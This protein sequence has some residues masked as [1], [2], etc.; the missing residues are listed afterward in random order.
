MSEA[1]VLGRFVPEF[2]AVTDRMQFNMYHHYTVDEHTLRA[3]D[4]IADIEHG[5]LAERHPLATAIMPKIVNRRALWLAMLLHD[6]GKGG[7]DQQIEGAKLASVAC[8][9]LGLPA[10]EVELI[11]WLV[12]HHLVMS[13]IAQR[14][15]L[16]DPRTISHFAEVVGSLERL[17]LLLVLTVADIRAVGPGVWNDWK[18]QLLRDLYRLT[19]ATLRGGRSDEEGVRER[20]AAMAVEARERLIADT[21]DAA[22]PWSQTL[23][24]AYWLS[25]D[26]DSHAWHARE[27]L[28]AL[29]SG[30]TVHIATRVRAKQGVT[31]VLVYAPDR[32]GLF[33]SLA[34]AMSSSAADIAAARVHTTTDRRALDVFSL[35]TVGHLPFGGDRPEILRRLAK[36]LKTAAQVDQP[37]PP[38]KAPSRRAAAFTIEPWVQIDNQVTPS[39]TVIEVSGRD[40]LG[41]LAEL[42]RACADADASIQSAHVDTLGERA[43]DVFYVQD[44]GHRGQLTEPARIEALR[45]SLMAV[46]RAADPPPASTD[47]PAKQLAVARA[48]T[49]R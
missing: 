32:P 11:A 3:I 23:D 20:L 43:A 19:E 12:R 49:A 30:E 14:R 48:S 37:A 47:A 40:R 21:G 9:R 10:E 34:A 36:R 38:A 18:G 39:A 44:V 46:L 16:A 5:R 31:E 15:D 22:R 41:L 45:S 42:A 24:D 8:M 27:S 29:A 17:R 13:E 25:H 26:A 35:Q 6:V 2:G 4:A 28:N 1:G 33:A 7:G